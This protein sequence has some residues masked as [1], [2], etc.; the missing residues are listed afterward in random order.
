MSLLFFTYYS[1]FIPVMANKGLQLFVYA[2]Y[3]TVVDD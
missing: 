3:S 2:Q 1:L